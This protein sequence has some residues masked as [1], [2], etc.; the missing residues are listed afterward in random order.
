LH[1]LIIFFYHSVAGN[2]IDL[3]LVKGE[4]II[5]IENK[6]ASSPVL[7]K[8][9]WK[10]IKILKPEKAYVIVPVSGSYLIKQNVTVCGLAD[11]IG[12]IQ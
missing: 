6:A 3:V 12:Q 2:E 5:E 10:S 1:K 4:R 8:G 11:L 7:K 9:F